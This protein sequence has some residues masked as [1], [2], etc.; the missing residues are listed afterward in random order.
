V[1]K[2]TKKHKSH[3]P[4]AG[5]FDLNTLKRRAWRYLQPEDNIIDTL[6]S[7]QISLLYSGLLAS[8]IISALLAAILAAVQSLVLAPEPV[9]IWLTSMG[10]VLL[11]RGILL[12]VWRYSSSKYDP[13]SADL[14]LNLFRIGAIATGVIWGI[15]GILLSLTDNPAHK[16]YVSF[17]LAGLS[18]GAAATL[19][20]D[21][22]SFIG[23]LLAVLIP[24]IIFLAYEGTPISFGMSIMDTLF[25]FFILSSTLKLNHHIEENFHL[26]KQATDNE[27]RLHQML[28]SSPIAAHITDAVSHEVVFANKSYSSLL[29]TMPQE[30]IGLIPSGYYA[31]KVYRDITEKLHKGESITNKLVELQSPGDKG[32]TKWVLASYFPLEY[33]DK[34]AILGWLYDITERKLME[35]KI[36][37]MAYHDILTGLPNRSQITAHLK[38]AI[39]NADQEDSVVALI[40]L[41]LDKFKYVNDEYGHQTG[42]LLLRAAA[43]RIDRC[44]RKSDLVA[45]VG[46]DEFVILLPSIKARKYALEIAEKIRHTLSQPFLI[47]GVTL[48]ISASIGVAIY[49]EDADEEQKLIKQ[50]D[51]AMYYAKSEGRNCVKSY[52]QTL[53]REKS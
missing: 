44:L 50:A 35:D 24:Q 53:R 4:E 49:P 14:W 3:R 40:F 23:Y 47:E 28:E 7:E 2:E 51:T 30:V 11:G 12:I 33:Q 15:G 13:S 38:E 39:I 45:R 6:S 18:A 42:D 25:L 9:T 10:M 34:P 20:I 19:F 26:R 16:I 27:V 48:D 1:N 8:L 46:G 52:P 5:S 41:D 36:K 22:V 29:D 21:R 43:Q 37:Y 32:W 31:P 17:V